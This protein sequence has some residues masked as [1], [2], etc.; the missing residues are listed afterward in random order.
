MCENTDLQPFKKF[1]GTL[2]LVQKLF[3]KIYLF[4][5]HLKVPPKSHSLSVESLDHNSDFHRVIA[6]GNCNFNFVHFSQKFHLHQLS[7][8]KNKRTKAGRST[9]TDER[10]YQPTYTCQFFHQFFHQGTNTINQRTNTF[11]V[12]LHLCVV[13]GTPVLFNTEAHITVKT[14]KTYYYSSWLFILISR[15]IINGQ[16]QWYCGFCEELS[17][18][19]SLLDLW[20]FYLT[21][22]G[23]RWRF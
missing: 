21:L 16:P 13:Q 20:V 22:Y 4:F 17:T 2:K 6:I 3:L 8:Q 11:D 9:H 15:E 19:T 18:H 23:G 5:Q 14:V 10:K 12:Q 7:P 1:S